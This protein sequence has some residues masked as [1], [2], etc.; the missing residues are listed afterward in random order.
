M[1]K[2]TSSTRKKQTAVK[3]T[4]VVEPTKENV[5][6][7]AEVIAE[8][9][10]IE[11]PPEP[12]KEPEPESDVTEEASVTESHEVRDAEPEEE[13]KTDTYT[14]PAAPP[15]TPQ[16]QNVF[17]PMVLGGLVAGAIGYGIAT[18]QRGD[19]TV[20]LQAAI[21]AQS[22]DI[23]AL[24][25]EVATL[26]DGPAMDGITEQ[27]AAVDQSVSSLSDRID[28]SIADLEDRIETVEKQP[29]A[30]G[31]LQEA[32]IAAYE[33]DLADLRD[34]IA[35]QQEELRTLL[36]ETR[37]EAQAIEENAIATARKAQARTALAIVRESLETGRPMGAALADLE[38]GIEGSLPE[39]LADAA[40]GVATL[41]SLQN[42]FPEAARAALAT[43][44]REGAAGEEEGG[45][46]GFLRNQLDVRSVEPQEGNSA[47]AILSRAEA[48]VREGRLNDTLAELATLPEVARAD[49]TDW[50]GQAEQRA[51]A[52]D[53]AATLASQ[54]NVN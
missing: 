48:A 50:I 7:D 29:S 30:D 43:A 14:P 8:D 11:T 33:R 34:Q 6:E 49:L 38:A 15:E 27:I 26:S 2:K 52:L 21:S 20:E 37:E 18:L 10:A 54:L 47:D 42:S 36:S 46:S 16:K 23:S 19:N 4:D 12:E 28:A 9:S 32:A 35:S 40:D 31:T 5:I 53:A 24:R 3:K 51:A 17:I 44:R 25:D 41:S 1:A 45:L 13:T 39:G 22:D